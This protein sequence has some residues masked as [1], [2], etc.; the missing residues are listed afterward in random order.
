M[1]GLYAARAHKTMLM[2][3]LPRT[4]E[5]D[6]STGLCDSIVFY[7]SSFNVCCRIFAIFT[8][9]FFQVCVWIFH[10]LILV[11][12]WG[13][14]RFGMRW[15][16]FMAKQSSQNFVCFFVFGCFLM[17]YARVRTSTRGS[18]RQTWRS[19]TNILCQCSDGKQQKHIHTNQ[20]KAHTFMSHPQIHHR[21]IVKL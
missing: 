19:K 15:Q 8:S 10:A 20:F 16:W 7:F 13:Y 9:F 11:C 21:I 17:S 1:V 5:E 3:C 12:V 18:Q 6:V 2:Q 4:N 14:F